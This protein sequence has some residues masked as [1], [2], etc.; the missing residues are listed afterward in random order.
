[1]PRLCSSVQLPVEAGVLR[2]RH[3]AFGVSSVHAAPLVARGGNHDLDPFRSLIARVEPGYVG[4]PTADTAQGVVAW[5]PKQERPSLGCEGWTSVRI[6]LPRARCKPGAA[7]AQV[8]RHRLPAGAV[9]APSLF[10]LWVSFITSISRSRSA[11]SR[12]S[13]A[14]Y[15]S[16]SFMCWKSVTSND[17]RVLRQVVNRLFT[18]TVFFAIS[19]TVL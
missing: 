16:I 18:H 5:R 17:P 7:T 15:C 13:R 6:A 14:F 10:F 4:S 9:R 3:I 2:D 8:Q 11:R 1:M 19:A 12:F